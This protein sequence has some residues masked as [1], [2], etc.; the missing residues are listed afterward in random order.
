M[1]SLQNLERFKNELNN[2]GH[3]AEVLARKGEHLEEVPPP[4]EDLSQT[5]A[6]LEA[7][8]ATLQEGRSEGDASSEGLFGPI[9]E[10]AGASREEVD[11]AEGNAPR[12]GAAPAGA[13]E[14]AS[15]SPAPAS[16]P[17]GGLVDFDQT[18]SPGSGLLRRA[19]A[20]A[21]SPGSIGPGLTDAVSTPLTAGRSAQSEPTG[22]AI[23]VESAAEEPPL[24]QEPDTDLFLDEFLRSEDLAEESEL[25]DLSSQ[26]PPSTEPAEGGPVREPGPASERGPAGE[27]PA[28]PA[29]DT[30][31]PLPQPDELEPGSDEELFFTVPSL[32]EL[33]AAE[34][35]ESGA[36]PEESATS[37]Q[38]PAGEE[39]PGEEV[40]AE[41]GFQP[42]EVPLEPPTVGSEGSIPGGGRAEPGG[43]EGEAS[44]GE[45]FGIEGLD[46][47]DD[48]GLEAQPG[49][50][51]ETGGR[52]EGAAAGVEALEGLGSEEGVP[53]EG[54]IEEP[55]WEESG[56]EKGPPA[57]DALGSGE[58]EEP[59]ADEIA[60]RPPDELEGEG[61]EAEAPA[62]E[63]GEIDLGEG[64]GQASE[65]LASL[66]DLEFTDD[67]FSG[68]QVAD[69]ASPRSDAAQ[70]EM[71]ADFALPPTPES[72]HEDT[73]GEDFPL[74][75]IGEQF[76]FVGEPPA[77]DEDLNPALA[78]GEPGRGRGREASGPDRPLQL[79]DRDF[80]RLQATL[81]TLPRNLRL[82]VAELIGE[83]GLAGEPLRQ[84]LDL[85]VA[86]A[87]P[88]EIAALTGR[89][90][91]RRV[92]VPA[93]YARRTGLEF[94][95][96]RGTFGY[97][98]RRNILPILQTLVFAGLA[99]ALVIFLGYRYVYR[100][101][102]ALTLYGIGYEDLTHDELTR[103][104]DY[105]DRATLEWRIKGWYYRYAEGF[106]EKKQY[107][108][109]AAK[110]D[111]LLRAYP[112]DRRGIF[113]YAHMES[114]ILGNYAKAEQLLDLIL[115][116]HPFDREALLAAGD[117]YLAWGGEDP[118][119]YELARRDYALI[120]EKYGVSN[121]VLF[122]MLRFFIKTDNY[123]EVEKLEQHFQADKGIRVDPIAYA[124]LG[125]YLI[126]KGRLGSVKDIL[127]R[128]LKVDHGLP[129]IHFNLARYFKATG[130][131][132][133]EA[134]A[135]ANT[136]YFLQRSGP[137]T[138]SRLAMMIETYDL[139]GENLYGERRYLDAQQ[140]Y[141]RGINLYENAL[142]QDQLR[143][144]AAFGKLYSDLGDLNYYQSSN[145]AEALRLYRQAEANG[146]RTPELK[147]KE[148]YI[149]YRDQDWANALL[150]FY[151]A[152]GNFSMNP[153][154]L[155]A[156]ANTLYK[157]SDFFAAE[158]YYDNLL[159]M[160]EQRRDEITNFQPDEVPADRILLTN[161]MKVYNNLGVTLNRI[162]RRSA[163]PGRYSQALVDL[164]KSS[165]SFD[166]LT[167][168]PSTMEPAQTINLAFINTKAILFPMPG[169]QVQL[170]NDLP[171]DLQTKEF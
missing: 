77:T 32:E 116:A 129:E 6:D 35:P 108:F 142:N 81:A 41:T 161:L 24:E 110:Y 148:G 23:P 70:R 101:F 146:Y 100:P 3:E 45:D 106:I 7:L 154:L 22:V 89:I 18:L 63:V 143:P 159:R 128:A 25:T 65:E 139:M 68:G 120:L 73:E 47:L 44:P 109:A 79:S 11:H 170:Y 91:G 20:R 34:P 36:A 59:F 160:L 97:R 28:A 113:D 27:E 158:G 103:A 74:G 94:E 10:P 162:A 87:P 171:K 31:F 49:A 125:G 50:E 144:A 5:D 16:S 40:P 126:D 64:A 69:A 123:P 107:A 127:M 118:S 92:V 58:L 52:I 115:K 98:F 57:D 2:L 169:Y 99:I 82:A 88:R 62:A 85:L 165:E 117:N 75:D 72:P 104:N 164:T 124:E 17:A 80:R 141:V 33:G 132:S 137:L 168:N 133:E 153:A 37:A 167:R 166:Q 56:P 96:E 135:L 48:A 13:A 55:A 122:R 105:F 156:T 19:A 42:E 4:V 9:P 155:Y 53:E 130:D 21:S 83:K 30:A 38:G 151:A 60:A 26:V 112:G 131:T 12:A 14:A 8:L 163:D 134:K 119:K 54:A 157:R 39:L 66:G 136:L 46:F 1:P 76:G 78:V 84:L 138:R 150:S 71:S 90:L 15:S 95:E 93:A 86:G 111:A 51:L 147:Y 140:A 145:Y 152:A 61:F 43:P 121:E 149:Y 102:H 114:A 67:L 29:G